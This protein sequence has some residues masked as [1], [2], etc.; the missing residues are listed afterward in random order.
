MGKQV[1]PENEQPVTVATNNSIQLGDNNNLDLSNLSP[2]AQEEVRRKHAL[3][4]VD[5]DAKA[6]DAQIELHQSSE[7]MR[8]MSNT[9][10]DMVDSGASGTISNSVTNSLGRTEIMMGN[11]ETAARGKLTRSATGESDNAVKIMM[12]IGV[13][14]VVI[15]LIFVMGQ[16]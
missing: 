16:K 3:A 7:N 15:A 8:A 12:I 13:F 10:K 14:A 2:E 6:K 9:V 1:V 5:I 4:M 11:T